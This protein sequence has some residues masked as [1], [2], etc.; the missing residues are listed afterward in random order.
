MPRERAPPR[1]RRGGRRHDTESDDIVRAVVTDAGVGFSPESIP[2][3]RLGF[4]ESVV[5][6]LGNVGGSARVFSTPGAGT[7]VMLEVPRR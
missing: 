5:A 3:D 1:G 7:T 4:R 2:P 6:R